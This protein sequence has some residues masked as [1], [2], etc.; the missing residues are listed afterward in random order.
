MQIDP[1]TFAELRLGNVARQRQW[2]PDVVERLADLAREAWGMR[3]SRADV[4]DLAMELADVIIIADLLAWKFDIDL[5]AAVR[6]KFNESS[7]RL[8]LD[9]RL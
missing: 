1:L 8:E 9:E 4:G 5:G 6:A 3:G 2:D 7:A